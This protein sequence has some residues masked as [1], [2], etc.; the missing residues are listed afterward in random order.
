MSGDVTLKQ[1]ED[2]AE[3]LRKLKEEKDKL[4]AQVDEINAK[5]ASIHNKLVEWMEEF[6]KTSYKSKWGTIICATKMSVKTPK[7][8]DSKAQFFAYLDQKGIKD[9]I[10][11]INSK[12]LNSMY[13]AEM[14]AARERGETE[15]SMPGIEAPTVYKQIS[16]RK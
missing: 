5:T 7:D 2:A 12:T 15:F 1:L 8:P 9:D 3:E 16:L 10:L 13:N 14:E 11:T 4:E 6:D